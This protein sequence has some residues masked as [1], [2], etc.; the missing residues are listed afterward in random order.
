MVPG[1]R[2]WSSMVG[3]KDTAAGHTVSAVSTQ[4][5][6]SAQVAFLIL[7]GLRGQPMTCFYAHSGWAFLLQLTLEAPSQTH[8]EDC[9]PSDTPSCQVDNVNDHSVIIAFASLFLHQ[10]LHHHKKPS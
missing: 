10:L 8:P 5:I 9:L 1:L 4:I 3:K 7:Y 6:A 2:V